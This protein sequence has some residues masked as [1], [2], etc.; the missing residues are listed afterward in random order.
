MLNYENNL[1]LDFVF[2]KT[3]NSL[4]LLHK[5]SE[6]TGPQDPGLP[7][8]TEDIIYFLQ[9]INDFISNNNEIYND[10]VRLSL[11]III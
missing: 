2:I 8:G 11:I 3:S 7:P 4:N 6:V 9:V 5:V 10:I 1:Y